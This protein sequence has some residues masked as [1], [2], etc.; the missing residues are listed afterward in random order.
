MNKT[1]TLEEILLYAYGE[2]CEMSDDAV[3][4]GLLITDGTLNEDFR[5]LNDTRQIIENSMVNPPD[6]IVSKIISY[7]DALTIL[8]LSE[9]DLR[10]MIKN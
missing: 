2:P 4:E 7:S 8:N 10:T 6:S 5:F 1:S 3:I 9:P